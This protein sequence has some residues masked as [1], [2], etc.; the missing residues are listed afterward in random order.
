MIFRFIYC[1]EPERII[2]AVLIDSQYT[3]PS[4]ANKVGFD[5]KSYTDAEVNKITDSV[6]PYKIET[7]LG[8]LAGYFTIKIQDGILF[9]YQLRPSFK[10]FSNTISKQIS[11]FIQDGEYKHDTLL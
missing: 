2:P 5:I 10:S 6:L 7:E 11:N 4:I 3:I 9:Q 1:E 8:V